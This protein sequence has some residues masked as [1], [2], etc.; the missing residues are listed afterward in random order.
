MGLNSKRFAL[1][2]GFRAG[3]VGEVENRT[4]A[5]GWQRSSLDYIR[6][7]GRRR[8]P[9]RRSRAL[10]PRQK[11]RSPRDFYTGSLTSPKGK[12]VKH[13]LTRVGGWIMLNTSFF[14]LGLET[15]GSNPDSES[16]VPKEKASSGFGR[17]S[18]TACFLRAL[19]GFRRWDTARMRKTWGAVWHGPRLRR[20]R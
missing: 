4:C 6:A 14:G 18:R 13:R 17:A 15:R 3:Q 7:R 11:R 1:Y 8:A 9:G 5:S 2:C 16:Q 20:L 12:S 19:G 10:C